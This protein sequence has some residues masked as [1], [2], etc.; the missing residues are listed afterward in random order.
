MFM[1]G[2]EVSFVAFR[3]IS[4]LCGEVQIPHAVYDEVVTCGPAKGSSDAR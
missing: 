2:E 4:E 3:G 1:A